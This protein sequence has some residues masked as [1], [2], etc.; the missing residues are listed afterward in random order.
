MF[1]VLIVIIFRGDKDSENQAQCQKQKGKIL[2]MWPI[3]MIR[4]DGLGA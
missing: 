1:F 4:H 3:H 2:S